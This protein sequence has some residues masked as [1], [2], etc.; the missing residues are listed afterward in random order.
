MS[1]SA[2]VRS[3]SGLRRLLGQPRRFDIKPA[4]PAI[5]YAFNSRKT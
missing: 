2:L 1:D 5:R 3:A 4:A